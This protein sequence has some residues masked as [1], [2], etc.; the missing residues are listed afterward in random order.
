MNGLN[1]NA[2]ATELAVGTAIYITEN[3]M[4]ANGCYRIVYLDHVYG[5]VYL[6]RLPVK[7][8][9][10]DSTPK[11]KREF[12][13]QRITKTSLID[14]MSE[15][16]TSVISDTYIDQP[17]TSIE[18]LGDRQ[19]QIYH[20]RLPILQSMLKPENFRALL[21]ENATQAI[22][23]LSES[24]NVT[25]IQVKRLFNRLLEAGLN[26]NSAAI[27]AHNRCGKRANKE[28]P[29]KQ[30]R[31]RKY[32]KNG[33]ALDYQ[34]INTSKDHLK[35][36]DIFIES[37]YDPKRPYAENFR[38]FKT[39]YAIQGHRISQDGHIEKTM[40]PDEQFISIDQF[41][42]H[43]KERI[44][45]KYPQL[46]STRKKELDNVLQRRALGNARN[47]VPFPA[48]SLIIDS[49]VADVYLVSAWDPTRIIGRPVIYAV[50]DAFSSAV[51]GVR[52][53]LENPSAK[54]AKTA[55]Y[56]ALTEKSALLGKHKLEAYSDLFP[57]CPIPNELVFDRAELLSQEGREIGS[58]LQINIGVPPAYF[59][60][61]KAIVER[62]FGTL[63]RT[64]IHW[65]PGSTLGKQRER[66]EKDVR[67]DGVLNLHEFTKLVL[68]G[69]AHW[70]SLG[71]P[72]S[73]ALSDMEREIE[74]PSPV[75]LFNW[76][77]K[78]LHG[79]PR[80]L[81]KDE[82]VFK[83]LP[84]VGCSI[85][86]KGIISEDLRWVSDWMN[87]I[88]LTRKG[89]LDRPAMLLRDPHDSTTA[90]VKIQ[91]EK[92][93]RRVSISSRHQI[94][95][96]YTTFDVDDLRA[97]MKDTQSIYQRKTEGLQTKIDRESHRVVEGAQKATA[98]ALSSTTP[99]KAKRIRM[100]KQNRSDEIA[101][102]QPIFH[103]FDDKR[104]ASNPKQ[105]PTKSGQTIS[106]FSS[107]CDNWGEDE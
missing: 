84:S 89:T 80:Y 72:H 82:A 20:Q 85:G 60:Q 93:L 28:Y 21:E 55:L 99:S 51:V 94:E 39:L 23:L 12:H 29:K 10:Q 38:K 17:L 33:R 104:E 24:F 47:S 48:H 30:G 70:N 27:T 56:S 19:K 58:S 22:Q 13:I 26:P 78:N 97:T 103:K 41:T 44:P 35:K 7:K 68:L 96:D 50:I 63:N 74:S 88:A 1:G 69:I 3:K 100:I 73:L 42:Y 6:K 91:A 83:L 14:L 90:W 57:T 64:T 18:E 2:P 95:C 65:L 76:G 46:T 45:V 86:N 101:G 87:D 67:L 59:P 9:S 106:G 105:Q 36:I 75:N 32:I 66:G 61:W 107:A 37:K 8:T 15:N 11:P 71:K 79:T 5:K 25:A 34:G 92:I 53:S 81:G 54:E 52:V 102:D 62:Y 40:L 77:L 16:K 43:L 4:I 49:T 31:P 98:F